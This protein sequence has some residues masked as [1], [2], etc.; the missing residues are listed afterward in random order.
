MKKI[1]VGILGA[2]G[3][4]G[5]Q[6]LQ[7][8]ANHPWFDICFLAA[9]EQS[10]G[11]SLSAAT[12]GRRHGSIDRYGNAP[13]FYCGDIAMAKKQECRLV[14]SALSNDAAA[15]YER[16]Y[17]EAGMAVISNAGFH[18]GDADVPVLIPEVN[19]DHVKVIPLQ[20]RNRNWTNGFIVAKPNCSI[21][22]YMIPLAL[23]HRDYQVKRLIVTTFQA[24][25]G[26]GYPGV[27]S[28]DITDNVIPY[29]AGEEEKSEREPLKLWGKI[30]NDAIIATDD[31]VISAHCNRVPVLDGH[32]ACV[33]V[34][35]AKIPRREDIISY[36][37]NSH[38]FPQVRGL[39]SS[40]ERAIVVSD[41]VDR[42]QPRHDRHAGNGMSVTVGR[43]RECPVLHYR[44]VALS[45]NTIR[46]AAGGGIL[47]A[48]FL[49]QQGYL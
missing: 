2:T 9:S 5:Q 36:W 18:R 42:P 4:V 1:R 38:A 3:M 46:G 40:P 48:E 47:N 44:F 11:K 37:H 15:R 7:L 13:V 24:V 16:C 17:A 39:P 31:M 8:L 22:S 20:Q 14:F 41:E 25:S 6:Y 43:L 34:E 35:F 26:A 33:S 23:L 28:L 21:Q 10:V 19:P 49:L 30:A 32:M 27:S 45:H 12:L 29:I